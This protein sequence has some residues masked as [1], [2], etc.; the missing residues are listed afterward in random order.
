MIRRFHVQ[1]D[2]WPHGVEAEVI[3]CGDDLSV[4][5]GGGLTYHI[6]ATALAVP[7]KSLA[8]AESTSASASV[9]CVV[10]HK[11]DELARKAALKLAAWLQ[12]TVNVT[13]GMHMDRATPADIQILSENY[14]KVLAEI[15]A[16][17][18]SP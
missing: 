1:A 7:R 6:G 5:I 8:D 4:Y 9:L 3:L 12:R 14:E 13:V 10:G 15:K 18:A 16:K 11:E 2:Q 17:L